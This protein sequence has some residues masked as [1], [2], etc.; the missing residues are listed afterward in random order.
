MNLLIT[1]GGTTEKID[2]VRSITNTS[3]GETAHTIA[4]CLYADGRN[5]IFYV[6]AEKTKPFYRAQENIAYESSK[7]LDEA[8]KIILQNT[9]IDVVIHSAAVSDFAVDKVVINGE[10]FESGEIKKISSLDD[11]EL[12]LKSQPKIIKKLR[13]YAKKSTPLIIG[14]KLTNTQD[15]DEQMD[16]VLNLSMTESVDFVVHN[17]LNEITN[18]QHRSKIFFRD[19]LIFSGE[20]KSEMAKNILELINTYSFNLESFKSGIAIEEGDEGDTNDFM[21]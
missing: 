11:V 4:D 5:K 18:D 16:Q 12:I 7:D 1:S 2:Q 20:T 17:D 8:L 15:K 10:L 6:H 19:Q 14:F 13:E 21:S 9:P 3:S